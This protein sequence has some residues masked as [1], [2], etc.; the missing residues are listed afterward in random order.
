MLA[1]ACSLLACSLASS[2]PMPEYI[3]EIQL[4]NLKCCYLINL[5]IWYDLLFL[6]VYPTDSCL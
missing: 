3:G 1:R 6:T 2:I 5:M 4:I